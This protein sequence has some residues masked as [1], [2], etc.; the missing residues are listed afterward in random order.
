[1]L[2]IYA[3]LASVVF[4]INLIP[5]FMPPTWIILT[6]FYITFDL[7]LVP[8]VIIG[9]VMA[10]LGRICL[11]FLARYYFTP[12]LSSNGKENYKALGA[13]LNKNKKITIPLII[14]YAFIPIPSNQV[15]MAVGMSHT[16]IR[17]F[18]TFFFIGRIISYAFWIAAAYKFH[19][20]FDGIFIH[21]FTRGTTIFIE[22]AGIL[23]LWLLSRIPWARF[24]ERKPESKVEKEKAY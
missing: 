3:I 7:K 18:A 24:L 12:L 9:A 16:D 8:T 10:T 22:I 11:A 15:Y 17:P 13:F 4:S 23:A 5:A 14:S 21:H 20:S 19:D 6:F 2:G 1:M